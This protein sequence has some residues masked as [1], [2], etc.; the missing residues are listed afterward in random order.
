M[1]AQERVKRAIHFQGPDRTPHFLPDGKENDLI[2]LWSQRPE[3]IKPWTNI[4]EHDEMIDAWGTTFRRVAGGVIGRGEVYRPV[5]P[6]IGKQADYVI[7]DMHRP[8]FFNDI[9]K[10]IAEN[11]AAENP[12]YLLATAP[13]CSLNEGTHN[14]MGLENMMLAYYEEPDELKAFIGRLAEAQKEST[15]LVAE[16]GCDGV[17]FYDDWGLQTNLMCSRELIEEFFM[18]HYRTNWGYARELGLDV[19]LHSCG[20]IV[21]ILD[22]FINAGL[23]VIQQDQQENMGIDLLNERFG[24]RLAFW[25]PVDIQCTM[26]NGTLDEIRAYAA[27]LV[28]TLGTHNGGFVSMAYSSPEDVNHTPEKLA[29]MSEAFRTHE[30]PARTRVC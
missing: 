12:K 30:R 3:P 16:L 23:N 6:D 28:Q 4:G 11:K 14:L 5:L 18:P 29:A 1:T 17:M 22:D 21:N 25:C 20:H 8:E 9:R 19:W 10:T 15:R 24:G 13:Y 26:I 27:K 2:W 7:P